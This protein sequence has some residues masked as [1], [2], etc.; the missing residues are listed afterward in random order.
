MTNTLFVSDLH[1][2]EETEHIEQGFY[3]FLNNEGEISR[4]FFIGR[5]F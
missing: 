2:S 5:Y 3:R 4:L 1:L